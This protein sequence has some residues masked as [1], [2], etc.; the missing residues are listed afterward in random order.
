MDGDGLLSHWFPAPLQAIPFPRLSYQLAR[1]KD[2]RIVVCLTT[3]GIN[4]SIRAPLFRGQD[5]FV[6]AA[7]LLLSCL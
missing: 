2:C 6:S 7:A 4:C 3:T 5:Q 1:S